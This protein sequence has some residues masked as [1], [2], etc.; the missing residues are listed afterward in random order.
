MR[1]QTKEVAEKIAG[2]LGPIEKV[3]IGTRGFSVGKFLR[4][5]VN[6]DISKPL[7]RGR[8]VRL[9]TKEKGWVDFRY[10]RLY[11]ATGAANW[12]M[13]IETAHSGLTATSH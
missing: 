9:G 7:C 11:F 1:M 3:D 5:R 13:M 2:P 4:I 12:T 8:V 10:E 6:I